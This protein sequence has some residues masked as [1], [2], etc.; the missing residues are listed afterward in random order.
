MQGEF[1]TVK[2]VLSAAPILIAYLGG[3]SGLPV[4]EQ[5]AW[6]LGERAAGAGVVLVLVLVGVMSAPGRGGPLLPCGLTRVWRQQWPAGGRAARSGAELVRPGGQWLALLCAPLAA[7]GWPLLALF[8]VWKVWGEVRLQ[9]TLLT[10]TFE[11]QH[12]P[13]FTAHLVAPPHLSVVVIFSFF[14]VLPLP[15]PAPRQHCCRG[16]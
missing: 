1:E 5:C 4:A 2:A 13:N 15:A 16:L 6:A 14:F 7:A 9:P 3:G 10:R 8:S 12:K 11:F